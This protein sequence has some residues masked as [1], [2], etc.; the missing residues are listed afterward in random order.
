M[1]RTQHTVNIGG[2]PRAEEHQKSTVGVSKTAV[3]LDGQSV[4]LFSDKVVVVY[5]DPMPA[6][7]LVAHDADIRLEFISENSCHRD[8]DSAEDVVSGQV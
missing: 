2:V 3:Q 6:H 8:A 7:E 4:R 5:A 1:L